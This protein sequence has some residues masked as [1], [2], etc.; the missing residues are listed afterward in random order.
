MTVLLL[1]S[2]S[3]ICFT[4]ISKDKLIKEFNNVHS[5]RLLRYGSF[6]RITVF[7]N[8]ASDYLTE[9]LSLPT[10]PVIVICKRLGSNLPTFICVN[11]ITFLK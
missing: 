11:F 8:N 5:Q 6:N 2:D 1:F 9:R 4:V 3:F 7:V 10:V